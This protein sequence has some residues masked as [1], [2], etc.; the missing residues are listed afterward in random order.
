MHIYVYVTRIKKRSCIWKRKREA[1]EELEEERDGWDDLNVTYVWTSLKKIMESLVD[2]LTMECNTKHSIAV[3]ANFHFL[4]FWFNEYSLKT[5]MVFHSNENLHCS[6]YSINYKPLSLLQRQFNKAQKRFAEIF[7][8]SPEIKT[9][10]QHP[11]L[12]N[13]GYGYLGWPKRKPIKCLV[14]VI[15]NLFPWIHLTSPSI[16]ALIPDCLLKFTAMCVGFPYTMT[17]F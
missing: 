14:E 11:I 15:M 9:I 3:S 5:S 17:L 7:F 10:R 4:L 16:D 13:G 6:H 1:L 8:G 12:I 2:S